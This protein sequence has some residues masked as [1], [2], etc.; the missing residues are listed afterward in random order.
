MFYDDKVIE[1]VKQRTSLVDLVSERTVVKQSG[2]NFSACCP[3][4]T[5]KT[6]SFHINEEEGL[7]YCFGCG[8][9]GNTFT[10]VMDT[11]SISFPEALRFLAQ[12]AGVSMPEESKSHSR[13]TVPSGDK[14]VLRRI[15][16]EVALIYEDN[17]WTKSSEGKDFLVKRRVNDYTAKRF[18]LGFAL[19]GKGNKSL[20]Q[21][22]Y[23]KVSKSLSVTQNDVVD[24]LTT[25]GLLRK[26]ASGN[27]GE[28]F[29]DRV[30]FPI[31][32]SDS[33][34]LAFGGRILVNQ[35]GSPKYINSPESP[36]FEK[37][38]SFYGLGQGFLSAQKSKQVHI[39]EGYL[40]VIS[41]SQLGIDNTFA[42]CGT[43]LTEDHVKILKRF[44]SKVVLIFDGDGAGRAA[45]AKTFAPFLNSGI[46]VV[47]VILD[48]GDDP[49]TLT[50]DRSEDQVRAILKD[51]EVSLL[52]LYL[53]VIA[54]QHRGLE[55][56]SGVELGTISASEAGK[57]SS[58]LSRVLSLVKNPVELEFRVREAASFLGVTE[59]SLLKMVESEKKELNSRPKFKSLV[60]Q[61]EISVEEPSETLQMPV[62]DNLSSRRMNI[63]RKQLLVSLIVEPSLLCSSSVRSQVAVLGAQDQ[64]IIMLARRLIKTDLGS[65]K[66]DMD[67]GEVKVVHG[68]S[69]LVS[70]DQEM[71]ESILALYE[72][73]LT[74]CGLSS[75]GLIEEALSQLSINESIFI[76]PDEQIKNR[77][78]LEF[79]FSHVVQK[80]KVTDELD[81]I[82]LKELEET[83]YDSR[84][85]LAQEK[86][87]RKR[88]ISKVT[89]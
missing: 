31:T 78:K 9:K 16:S 82:R 10:F 30:M 67:I 8:K 52:K 53:E 64:R 72:G 57:I 1:E 26:R 20:S 36:V 51:R 49:D 46:E 2:K 61:E 4:H 77:K 22:V 55:R 23:E 59:S 69:S 50:Y 32:K 87:L 43:A 75:E 35:E 86:L 74:E 44:V 56:G 7:Y 81:A 54:G 6:P 37:R 66:I 68:L 34:P 27:L 25:L 21:L 62:F 19:S 12:R 5:E 15:I 41:L 39:V 40:D 11:R 48:S 79:E 60:M 3:F 83:D 76:N 45:A 73:I 88:S 65:Q 13:R 38:R 47:P 63:V 84:I 80:V 71:R 85:N 89:K 33:S 17:L 70:S 29:W 14:N 42:V 58:D 28:L 18:R 24:A